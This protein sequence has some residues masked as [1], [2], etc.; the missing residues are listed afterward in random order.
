MKTK[1]YF[2]LL[3]TLFLGLNS[4][5]QKEKCDDSLNAIIN[6]DNTFT[7]AN[8]QAYY[9]EIIQGD[10]LIVGPNTTKTIEVNCTGN[11]SFFRV[12]LTRFINGECIEACE[13]FTC[14]NNITP[15]PELRCFGYDPITP[16][17]VNSEGKLNRAFVNYPYSAPIPDA[18]LTFTWY[19]K[20]KNGDL[21][22]FYV[23]NPTFR[24]LCPQNPVMSFGLIVSNGVDSIK[25]YNAP[26]DSE[27]PTPSP[28]LISEFSEAHDSACVTSF[29]ESCNSLLQGS[30]ALRSVEIIL[31]KKEQLIQ[32]VNIDNDSS[33]NFKLYN[34]TGNLMLSSDS[35]NDG[36]EISKLKEGIYLYNL[37]TENGE[38]IKG[39]LIK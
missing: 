22:M 20:F 27:S 17:N 3:L 1:I 28:Y 18:G 8:A 19:F 10:A 31:N 6:N 4:F 29:F 12:K 5:A 13:V 38:V 24:E 26:L 14:N 35:V 23:Q 32:F 34:L 7:A 37:T 39:K 15:L 25:L 16:I 9:W 21:K 11:N 36:I 33:Y 30:L 2:T